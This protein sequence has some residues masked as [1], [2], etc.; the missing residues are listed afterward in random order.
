LPLCDLEQVRPSLAM[1]LARVPVHGGFA[2]LLRRLAYRVEWPV[3]RLPTTSAAAHPLDG[4]PAACAAAYPVDGLPRT[5]AAAYPAIERLLEGARSR[6]LA[7]AVD[8]ARGLIGLGDGLTPS[9]DDLL[10]GFSAGLRAR[11]SPLDPKFAQAC[12]RLAPGRTT[13]VAEVYLAGA[14]R[15]EYSAGIHR[16]VRALG[17]PA[18]TASPI[19]GLAPAP[20]FDAPPPFD[21]RLGGTSLADEFTLALAW[22]A[23]SGAD[24]LLGLLLGAGIATDVARVIGAWPALG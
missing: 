2:P 5:C 1:V 17:A 13:R 19:A 18:L 15:G 14:A 11:A 8:A 22:G 9:G 10:V 16:L 4:L 6:D 12:A 24:T 23:S 3:D 20:P 7:R 21:G